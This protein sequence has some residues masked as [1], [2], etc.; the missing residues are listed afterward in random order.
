MQH[1]F[2]GFLI[3]L[4]RSPQKLTSS[5]V[6]SNETDQLTFRILVHRIGFTIFYFTEF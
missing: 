5:N 3:F 6:H 4:P 1:G 2:R